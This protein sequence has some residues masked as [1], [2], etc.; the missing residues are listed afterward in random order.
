MLLN[1]VLVVASVFAGSTRLLLKTV[2]SVCGAGSATCSHDGTRR[3][4]WVAWGSGSARGS[5]GSDSASAGRLLLS[6][7]PSCSQDLGI[8]GQP[9]V[10]SAR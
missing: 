6:D 10:T 4:L 1:Q 9:E 7:V 2:L 3:R 8:W 5:L